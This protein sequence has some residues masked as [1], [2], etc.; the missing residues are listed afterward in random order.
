MNNS[1]IILDTDIGYDPDDLFALLFLVG[2]AG[3]RLDLIVTANEVDG[4]RAQ[5]AQM[6]INELSLPYVHVVQGS[7]LG[8]DKFTVDN[9]LSDNRFSNVQNNYLELIKETIDREGTVTYIGIGGFTN[10]AHFIEK[11]PN[12]AKRMDIFVMGGAVNYERNEGWTEYNIRIDPLSARKIVES[13]LNIKYIMAQTTHNPLYIVDENH[14]L[15]EQLKLSEKPGHQLLY[16]HCK[17][18]FEK[19]GHGTSMHD[20]LTVSCALGY[21]F[22]QFNSSKVSLSEEGKLVLNDNGSLIS[23][24]DPNSGAQSFMDLIGRILFKN[25]N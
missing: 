16:E 3:D 14:S 23:W 24:S 8:L 10:L 21:D 6:I 11:Y 1:K 18:W 25:V 12:E 19:R 22:V 9:L 5:F 7:S 17:L 15:Y 4:K 2:L 20:P 13:G